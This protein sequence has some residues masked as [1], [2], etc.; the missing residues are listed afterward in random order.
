MLE[1]ISLPEYVTVSTGAEEVIRKVRE[2]KAE[3]KNLCVAEVGIG[4]GATAIEIVRSL[5]ENDTYYMFDF[6]D[7]VQELK[8]DLEQLDF[9][10]T[11]IYA[12]GNS[13]QTYDSYAW[14]L[15][16]LWQESKDK[17]LFDVIYLDG[18]HSLFHDGLACCLLKKLCKRGGV[19]FLDDIDWTYCVS[20]RMRE[21]GLRNYTAEQVQTCQIDMVADIFMRDDKEWE[22]LKDYS[23]EH[24][25]AFRRRKNRIGLWLFGH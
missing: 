24:R 10:R 23:T 15:A 22:Y 1:K 17:E 18:A 6:E 4:V 11:T 19:L 13:Y 16:K 9:F 14:T 8:T 2:L 21:F 12:Y 20:E 7:N 25:A 5:D 3:G